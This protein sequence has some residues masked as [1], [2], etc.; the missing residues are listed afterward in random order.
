MGRQPR[1]SKEYIPVRVPVSMPGYRD[2]EVFDLLR[3]FDENWFVIEGKGG[4]GSQTNLKHRLWA[5]FG[6]TSTV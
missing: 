5:S 3:R 4:P 6:E 1:A 2:G